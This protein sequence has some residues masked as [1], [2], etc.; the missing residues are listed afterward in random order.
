MGPVVPPA[1]P[2]VVVCTSVV[3]SVTVTVP[4][5]TGG[6]TV[7]AGTEIKSYKLH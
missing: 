1:V 2:L 3:T 7:T 4:V 6:V 5:M